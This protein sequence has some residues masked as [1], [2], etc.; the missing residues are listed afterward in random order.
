[1]HLA[2]NVM[3]IARLP[4]VAATTSDDLGALAEWG[5]IVRPRSMV[6]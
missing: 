3:L 4:A 1:M 2:D 5:V 6:A